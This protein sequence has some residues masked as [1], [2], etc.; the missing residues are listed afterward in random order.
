MQGR[1]VKKIWSL[2]WLGG[3]H[4][5]KILLDSIEYLLKDITTGSNEIN[6]GEDQGIQYPDVANFAE[7]K[8]TSRLATSLPAKFV[9]VD[10]FWIGTETKIHL[11]NRKTLFQD[12]FERKTKTKFIS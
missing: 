10:I 7:L 8:N 12:D 4:E 2:G 5:E 11:S 1:Q 3:A 6:Y 9:R